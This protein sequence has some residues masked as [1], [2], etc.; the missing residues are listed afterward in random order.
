[1]K[2]QINIGVA[3]AATTARDFI[4][5]WK[6]AE[7]GKRVE[8]EIK[9]NFQ[10]LETLLKTITTGRWVLLKTLHKMG[11]TS[12]RALANELARDY[13]N[14]YTDVRL[15]ENVGLIER[16]RDDKVEVPWDTV[17]ARLQL[18]A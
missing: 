18:A 7:R 13:K 17:E 10:S 16:T 15:L 1:M 14:A 11:P 5:V 6:R 2:K 3:D 4:D 9:L 8:T 12:I